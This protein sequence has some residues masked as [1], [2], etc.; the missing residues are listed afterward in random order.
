MGKARSCVKNFES[1]KSSDL[2]VEKKS[3][4][5]FRRHR[6]NRV[7]KFLSG[8]WRKEV[9]CRTRPETIVWRGEDL[10][11]VGGCRTR[12]AGETETHGEMGGY[13]IRKEMKGREHLS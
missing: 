12:G 2:E 1:D 7:V 9:S 5:F 10:A 3:S 13:L 11:V 4:D 6:L 8:I